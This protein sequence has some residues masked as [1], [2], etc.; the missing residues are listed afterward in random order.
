MSAATGVVVGGLVEEGLVGSVIVV[1]VNE[2]VGST[3][4]GD[5][6]LRSAEYPARAPTPERATRA[7]STA[8]RNRR[9]LPRVGRSG[10]GGSVDGA[11]GGIDG[12]SNSGPLTCSTPTLHP[13]RTCLS[14]LGA[15]SDRRRFTFLKGLV[16][17]RVA[18][19]PGPCHVGWPREHRRWLE[20]PPD[21]GRPCPTGQR[22]P[23][24][25]SVTGRSLGTGPPLSTAS[26]NFRGSP[27][28]R[29]SNDAPAPPPADGRA[30]AR[31]KSPTAE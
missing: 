2:G 16:S 18:A 7:A 27:D 31:R 11:G 4:G 6:E 17:I 30:T 22:S 13:S 19:H 29:M 12:I 9:A 24:G 26:L 25:I 14:W 10:T 3:T 15:Q 21:F 1:G 28:L 8:V 20:W 23:S 5:D